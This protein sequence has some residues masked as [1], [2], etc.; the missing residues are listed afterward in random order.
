VELLRRVRDRFEQVILITHIEGVKEGLDRVIEVSYDEDSGAA[1]VD[2][3]SDQPGKAYGDG[4]ER[5]FGKVLASRGASSTIESR[6]H[7][8]NGRE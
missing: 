7:G 3:T 8:G 1:V 4:V 2:Q 6:E 5:A